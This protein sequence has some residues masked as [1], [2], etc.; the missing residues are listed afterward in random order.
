MN[1]SDMRTM[2]PHARIYTTKETARKYIGVILGL[3]R[4]MSMGVSVVWR[5]GEKAEL[6]VAPTLPPEISSVTQE[7]IDEYAALL[8]NT[9]RRGRA[10]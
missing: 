7:H 5:D 10:R 9:H 1:Q 3:Y 2:P 8:T 6:F 4:R